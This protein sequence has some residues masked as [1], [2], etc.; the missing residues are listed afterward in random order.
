MYEHNVVF[1]YSAVR[2]PSYSAWKVDILF[3]PQENNHMGTPRHHTSTRP[4]APGTHPGTFPPSRLLVMRNARRSS[5]Q[6]PRMRLGRPRAPDLRR[7]CGFVTLLRKHIMLELVQE[8]QT[9]G[10]IHDYI[11]VCRSHK[12]QF[13]FSWHFLT[14]LNVT[15]CLCFEILSKID[16]HRCI[17]IRLRL[18]FSSD[19][20]IWVLIRRD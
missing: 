4:V 3:W 1:C 7:D 13:V 11:I 8:K 17:R 10:F 19:Q 14:N 6:H 18:P 15:I 20:P 12:H 16:S 9:S 5:G 2:N